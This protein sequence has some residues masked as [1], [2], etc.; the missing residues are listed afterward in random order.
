MLGPSSPY[1]PQANPVERDWWPMRDRVTWHHRFRNLDELLEPV[2]A[3]LESESPFWLKDKD[4]QLSKAASFVRPF[5][6]KFL[7]F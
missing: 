2:L 1:N 4:D 7:E 6:G 5:W 3:Y